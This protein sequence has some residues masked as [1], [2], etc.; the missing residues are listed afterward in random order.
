MQGDLKTRNDLSQWF[1]CFMVKFAAKLSTLNHST[2]ERTD[3]LKTKSKVV[4]V[5]RHSSEFPIAI[6]T[7]VP[8][9]F[10]KEL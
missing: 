6:V 5:S 2:S 8:L 1:L 7:S 3:R 4:A 9:N 10:F